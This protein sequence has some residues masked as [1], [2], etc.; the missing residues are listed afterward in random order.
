M[1]VGALDAEEDKGL[2]KMV[3]T[4]FDTKMVSFSLIYN[5]M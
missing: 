1:G 5:F 4:G 3:I 2:E